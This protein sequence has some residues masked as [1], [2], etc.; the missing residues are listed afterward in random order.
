VTWSAFHEEMVTF[1]LELC[2]GGSR[3]RAVRPLG[4]LVRRGLGSLVERKPETL[5]LAGARPG[6]RVVLVFLLVGHFWTQSQRGVLSIRFIETDPS[7]APMSYQRRAQ[8]DDRRY[9][10]VSRVTVLRSQ[11]VIVSIIGIV[12]GAIALVRPEATLLTIAVI[13]GT[14]LIA[15][16]IIRLTMAITNRNASTGQRGFAGSLGVVILIAGVVCLLDPTE[17]LTLLAYVIGFGWVAEGII[18]LTGGTRATT[19]PRWL[20]ILSGVIS[21]AAGVIVFTLP[22]LAISVFISWGAIL[23]II[24]SATTLL[25]WPSRQDPRDAPIAHGGK[26]F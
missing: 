16:G 6:R 15:S 17:S 20:A 12:V 1:P 10:S 22:T 4:S 13:F 21:I 11:I 18:D 9:E 25:T 5:P 19:S 14:Y 8:G 23:L 3:L 24:V 2:S 7:E 26:L